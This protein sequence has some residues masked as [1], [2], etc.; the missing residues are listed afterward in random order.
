MN[1]VKLWERY[2]DENY[3]TMYDD[4]PLAQRMVEGMESFEKFHDGLDPAVRNDMMR[5]L[6]S[7]FEWA[8]PDAHT[9]RVK[10]YLR[11]VHDLEKRCAHTAFIT[12]YCV[13][14]DVMYIPAAQWDTCEYLC[15]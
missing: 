15:K 7:Y 11:D 14:G 12:N 2:L 4:N 8:P 9:T 6:F 10:A 1:R 3:K 13:F 5:R